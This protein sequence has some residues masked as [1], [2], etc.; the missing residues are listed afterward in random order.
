MKLNLNI[1]KNKFNLLVF[2]FIAIYTLAA[3]IVS[4]LR[5]YQFETHYFDFG[6]F[7]KA[8]WEASRLQAPIVY[9]MNFDT[10]KNIILADHFNPS[11]F[12][13]SPLFWITERREI[14]L[15]AQ[16]VSVGLSA[17]IGFYIART[18]VKSKIA[19]FALIVSY[20][21]F[22]GMQ[23][24]LITDFH[25]AT[26]VTVPLMLSIWAALKRKWK[27]FYVCLFVILGFKEAFAGLGVG[28]GL[29]LVI[30]GRENRKHTV[31]TI[32]ISLL[33][34]YLTTSII[35]PHLSGRPYFYAPQDGLLG[36][37]LMI[38]GILSFDT[39]AKTL[40]YSFASFGFLPAF[41][42]PLLPAISENLISR[43]ISDPARFGLQFHYSAP[44][45]ALMFFS[46]A[47]VF[48]RMEK[49]KRLVK[50]IVP[51]SVLIIS[52]VF[53]MHQFYLRGPL[54]LA[55]N[56]TFYSQTKNTKYIEDFLK[57]MPQ[58]GLIMTQNDL[59]VRFTHGDVM[60]LDKNYL[61]KKPTH[62]ILNLTPG[63]NLNNYFPLSAGDAIELK[64]LLLYDNNYK[65]TKFGDELYLFTR[66]DDKTQH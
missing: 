58:N 55:Y 46:S 49:S 48:Q 31:T 1:P 33:W 45:S 29:F 64:N 50:I 34:A 41:Y 63:Q 25:E 28:L 66:I 61:D 52:F 15:I 9:H 42:A 40:F 36:V 7:D 3:I 22:I 57:K 18:L 19:I 65:L 44:L 54:A 17:V 35:I 21:G 37:K 53:V 39:R 43:F 23:N 60:L 38:E 27:L 10:G 12:L 59:S 20:L 2:F 13:L 24:A 6:I 5:Y 32:G 4:V 51:Y 56:P 8:I 16:A 62:V 14:L 47:F 26:I 30:T 11:I